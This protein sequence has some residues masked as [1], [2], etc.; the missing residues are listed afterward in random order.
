MLR[1][2]SNN[3]SVCEKKNN[4]PEKTTHGKPSFRAPTQGLESSFRCWITYNDSN[5]NNN[6]NNNDNNNNHHHNHN[7]I[8]IL[9]IHQ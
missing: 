5:N 7:N 2:H 1:L 3:S 6:N 8:M 9:T 4:A